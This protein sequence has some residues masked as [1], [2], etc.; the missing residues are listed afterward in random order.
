MAHIRE[1]IDLYY[2]IV[3]VGPLGYRYTVLMGI[4]GSG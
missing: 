3:H 4:V 1:S 2:N